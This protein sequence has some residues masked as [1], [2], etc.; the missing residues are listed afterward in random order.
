MRNGFA[1]RKVTCFGTAE[2]R[3][4][5]MRFLCQRRH[6]TLPNLATE[7]GVS[8]RTIQ[9][10]IDEISDILP[11]YVKAGRYSGGVYV[12]DGFNFDRMY[13][14]DNEIALLEKISKERGK[15]SLSFQESET[16]NKI[17]MNYKKPAV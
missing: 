1:K 9:R 3:L 6:E 5:L 14:N 4:K 15:L 13:M 17:I 16:L 12:I 11:I 8:V 2:R 7:F 10:D